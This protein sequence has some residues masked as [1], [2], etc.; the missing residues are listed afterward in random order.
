MKEAL[1]ELQ[2]EFTNQIDTLQGAIDGQQAQLSN[3]INTLA[4]ALTAYQHQ[5]PEISSPAD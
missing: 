5:D 3:L 1:D 4:S 2:N